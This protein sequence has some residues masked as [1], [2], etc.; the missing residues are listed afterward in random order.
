MLGRPRRRPKETYNNTTNF[1]ITLEKDTGTSWAEASRG[2]KLLQGEVCLGEV[3]AAKDRRLHAEKTWP[4]HSAKQM[5][6]SNLIG[7][8]AFLIEISDSPNTRSSI[9]AM[10]NSP[11][12][13]RDREP[14]CHWAVVQHQGIP[15]WSDPCSLRPKPHIHRYMRPEMSL[16]LQIVGYSFRLSDESKLTLLLLVFEKK[17][18]LLLF[19]PLGKAR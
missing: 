17:S 11:G 18:C 4:S 3:G 14:Y 12:S 1:N 8:M 15:A 16:L 9:L 2:K 13:P 6:A 10:L 7:S 19:Y 5:G